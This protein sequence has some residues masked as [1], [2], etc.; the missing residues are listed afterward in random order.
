MSE[1]I[2]I[3]TEKLCRKNPERYSCEMDTI[4]GERKF[5]MGD[6]IKSVMIK[7]KE[8]NGK[9]PHK[10]TYCH[11]RSRGCT[12]YELFVTEGYLRSI[13]EKEM[14]EQEL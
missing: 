5:T 8:E 14:K 6:F 7:L 4:T 2:K 13:L 1:A 9:Y 10:T 3:L 12:E 11:P